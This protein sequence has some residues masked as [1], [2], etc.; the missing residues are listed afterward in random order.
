[1]NAAQCHEEIEIDEIAVDDV[2]GAFLDPKMVKKAPADEIDYVR[3]MKL[4]TCIHVKANI[5]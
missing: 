4:Y 5:Q 1:M 3:T 2:G